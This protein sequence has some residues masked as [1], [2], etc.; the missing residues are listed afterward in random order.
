VSF[1]IE[2]SAISYLDQKPSTCDGR[3]QK[4]TPRYSG[5]GLVIANGENPGY[6]RAVVAPISALRSIA[7]N[8]QGVF[9]LNTVAYR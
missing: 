4:G 1:P 5:L 3:P 9:G 6:C 7:L 8:M 2:S